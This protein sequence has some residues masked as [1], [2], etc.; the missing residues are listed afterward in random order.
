MGRA[1]KYVKQIKARERGEQIK[2]DAKRQ[3]A[4]TRPKVQRRFAPMN[5]CHFFFE[6]I[7]GPAINTGL[8][9]LG[10]GLATTSFFVMGAFFFTNEYFGNGIGRLVIFALTCFLFSLFFMFVYNW[11]SWGLSW[12]SWF[13]SKIP[14][15]RCFGC[16]TGKYCCG[17]H[18]HC[19]WLYVSASG[20]IDPPDEDGSDSEP[21]SISPE[22]DD[23]DEPH[24]K[25]R[26]N[27]RQRY[28]Q[29]D[30]YWNLPPYQQPWGYYP[31]PQAPPPA[32]SAA[33]YS[34]PYAYPHPP[35][36][37]ASPPQQVPNLPIVQELPLKQD[38]VANTED[39]IIPS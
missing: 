35:Q 15:C 19:G 24:R 7:F 28:E 4:K 14:C 18:R 10:L 31:P 16:C 8:G 27:N 12:I 34:Q 22:D 37:Q 30:P 32:F 17:K 6:W 33:P 29:I 21:D 38:P 25:P 11:L 13:F 3:A 20:E 2:R 1:D 5:A 39:P 23:Y 26:Y 36:P 9:W